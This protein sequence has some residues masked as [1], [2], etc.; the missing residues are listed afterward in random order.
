MMSTYKT[1]HL[2]EYMELRSMEENVEWSLEIRHLEGLFNNGLRMYFGVQLDNDGNI[3]S[4]IQQ[5]YEG[6]L[7]K[8]VKVNE[9]LMNDYNPTDEDWDDFR[10]IDGDLKKKRVKR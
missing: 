9:W 1:S 7:S 2:V 8:W 6:F 3:L 10:V 5:P 4:D